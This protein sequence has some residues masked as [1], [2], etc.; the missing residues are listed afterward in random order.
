MVYHVLQDCLFLRQIANSSYQKTFGIDEFNDEHVEHQSWEGIK[1]EFKIILE[2][3]S[4]VSNTTEK[5]GL[6]RLK[7]KC[8][9]EVKAAIERQLSLV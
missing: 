3:L 8:S 6:E 5:S 9:L 7:A 2:S 1:T 4:K